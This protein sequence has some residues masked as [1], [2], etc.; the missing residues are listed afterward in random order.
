MKRSLWAVKVS[1]SPSG[2]SASSGAPTAVPSAAFS[3]SRY[4]TAVSPLANVG[5]SLPTYTVTL[6]GMALSSASLA[7]NAIVTASACAMCAVTVSTAPQS[8]RR[9]AG[10]T[11]ATA[12]CEAVAVHVSMSPSG[13]DA[14]SVSA[15]S[16]PTFR[17]SGPSGLTSSIGASFTAST[18]TV[19][20]SV[21]SPPCSSLTM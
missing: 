18:V 9:P 21:A 11:L 6:A 2:S 1:S 4:V 5:I 12:G 19:T 15:R 7:V 8:S 13:S 14:P 17:Y 10:I 3:A 20:S 16:S